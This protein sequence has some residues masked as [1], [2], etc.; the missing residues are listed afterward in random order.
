MNL[1]VCFLLPSR[2]RCCSFHVVTGEFDGGPNIAPSSSVRQAPIDLQFHVMIFHGEYRNWSLYSYSFMDCVECIVGDCWIC[3]IGGLMTAQQHFSPFKN[4][5]NSVKNSP[6]HNNTIKIPETHRNKRR[7][8]GE[9]GRFNKNRFV[10]ELRELQP[11]QAID[12]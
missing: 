3:N 2:R 12:G 7:V 9:C 6:H 4:N 1:L 10:R 11:H 8:H 5:N